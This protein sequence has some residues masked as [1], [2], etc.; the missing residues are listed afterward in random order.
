MELTEDFSASLGDRLQP[1][2]NCKPKKRSKSGNVSISQCMAAAGRHQLA[3]VP[4]DQRLGQVETSHWT[5]SP[6]LV[7]SSSST[8]LRG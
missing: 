8:G 2:I 6:N 5:Q 7:S 4:S 3:G 1:R